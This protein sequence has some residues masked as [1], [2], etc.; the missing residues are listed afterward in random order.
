MRLGGSWLGNTAW[1][2]W[3]GNLDAWT[4]ASTTIV[5]CENAHVDMFIV[6]ILSLGKTE[7]GYVKRWEGKPKMGT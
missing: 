7:D 4:A 5:M 2:F 3:D 1:A 6:K